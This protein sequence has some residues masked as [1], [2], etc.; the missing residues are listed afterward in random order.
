MTPDMSYM[1]APDDLALHGARVLGFTTASRIAN[2]FGLDAAAT[3]E[4]LL[5][6]EAHG[7]AGRHSFAGS[8]GWSLTDA[9]RIENERRLAA[10]LDD[11]R[12]RAT[13]IRAHAAFVPLNERL[14]T[15]CT[16]WQIRPTQADSMAVNDHTDW[17]W[18]ER[19]LGTLASLTITFRQLCDQLTSCLQ[20]YCGYSDLFSAAVRKAEAGQRAWVDSPDRD[21]CHL[22]WM[23]FHQDLLATLGLPRGSDT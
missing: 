17:R 8:S 3:S 1:S 6:F 19:V 18:D 20:R 10:E 21:S 5:D 12:C 4:Y 13:V 14:G 16:D 2:R 7:W 22:V 23:Q 15:A 11:A 9:G